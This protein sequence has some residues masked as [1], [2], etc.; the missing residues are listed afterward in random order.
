M[1]IFTRR[2]PQ[3]AARTL[4]ASGLTLAPYNTPRTIR[5]SA[6]KISLDTRSDVERFAQQKNR[7][8]S[9]GSWQ[10]AAWAYYDSVGE[11]KYAFNLLGNV[12]SRLR[13]FP[14]VIT[15]PSRPP[16]ATPDVPGLTPGLADTSIRAL[17]KLNSGLGGI[18]SVL[19]DLAI[20]LSV[21]GEAYL[22]QIPERQG[23][24]I[25]ESWGIYSA[26]AIQLNSDQTVSLK[27]SPD[28][29]QP[30]WVKLPKEAFVGRIWRSHP[31]WANES[32]SSMRGL[33]DLLEEL[34]LLNQ[35]VKATARSRLNAGMLY[36]PDGLSASTLSA[37][38]YAE[39]ATEETSVA[40]D[41]DAFEIEL[42]D[43]MTS[44]ISEVDSAAAVVPLIVRGPGD[45]ADKIKQF[46]F[47]RSFDP[48][49]SARADRVLERI[50][51]GLDVP[52]EIITGL[53]SVKY[54]NAVVI[55][56]NFFRSNIEPLALLICDAL[57]TV[58]L[59]PFIV[60][61]GYTQQQAEQMVFWYDASEV[62][63][64][65]NRN[66]DA[67]QGYD[68]YILS[69]AAWRKTHGFTETDA[70]SPN[71]VLQ[72]LVINKGQIPDTLTENLLRVIAPMMM[73]EARNANPDVNSN[74]PPE[75]QQ[76]LGMSPSQAPAPDAGP[77]P[78]ATSSPAPSPEPTPFAEPTSPPTPTGM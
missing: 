1:A 6:Q 35:A 57:T 46:K 52:K 42:M 27:L 12:I 72:R 44:P 33:L 45:L 36:L 54:S 48:E 26:D 40:D 20:N 34:S 21:P 32:D 8:S 65:P 71:E 74:L 67:T 68:R 66:D 38:P 78:T 41:E 59:R 75:V 51:Q 69:N 31:R 23:S 62:V 60:A 61:N 47:E 14:A 30:D 39:E 56:D 7:S 58:Y 22:V 15:D 73:S 29:R 4:T 2:V 3:S 24:K 64:R 53:T 37:T 63:T 28:D 43:A 17:N 19:R 11:V 70:P 55:D 25:P 76:A 18:P 77:P 13:L 49:L 16:A 50:L 9:S 10:N 5:A